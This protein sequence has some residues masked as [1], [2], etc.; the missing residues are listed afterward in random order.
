MGLICPGEVDHNT[1]VVLKSA[2]LGNRIKLYVSYMQRYENVKIEKIPDLFLFENFEKTKVHDINN[3]PWTHSG[4]RLL[5]NE[6][7]VKY[8]TGEFKTIDQ[9]YNDTP[10]YFID[11]YLPVWQKLKIQPGVQKIIDSV[12]EDWDKDD[13]IGIHV[14]TNYPPVDDGSRSLWVDFEVFEREIESYPSTQKFFL[15]TDHGPI[16]DRYKEKYGDRIITTPK[17]DIVKHDNK[18]D[19]VYQT[20]SAFVDMYLLSQCYKKL[21]LT[22]ATSFSECS[23]WFGG[24]RAEVVMPTLWDK[25]PKDFY[26]IIYNRKDMTY[27]LGDDNEEVFAEG[28]RTYPP[29]KMGNDYKIKNW[30]VYDA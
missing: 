25:V 16:A 12:T 20:V 3:H 11:K 1:F 22:W 24:C 2:G 8:C 27:T 26:D 17:E 19:E 13:M 7:E 21:I 4:W 5:V 30:M 15:A 28:C 6:D 9:L 10:Q 18:V 23:W 14:R 29:E